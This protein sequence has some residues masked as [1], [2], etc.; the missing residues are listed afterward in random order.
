MN[1]ISRL[2]ISDNTRSLTE[3]GVHQYPLLEQ[4]DQRTC[5]DG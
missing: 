2:V 3:E 4:E 1:G 5:A